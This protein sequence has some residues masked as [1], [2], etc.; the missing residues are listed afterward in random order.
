[1]SGV[2]IIN[3]RAR[4][5]SESAASDS[6]QPA[7]V[8]KAKMA[9]KP[10]ASSAKPKASSAKPR[11]QKPVPPVVLSNKAAK[12]SISARVVTATKAAIVL[13]QALLAGDLKMY[14]VADDKGGFRYF[15]ALPP[16]SGDTVDLEMLPGMRVTRDVNA[17]VSYVEIKPV[18]EEPLLLLPVAAAAAACAS[19]GGGDNASS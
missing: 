17:G 5:E 2:V 12:I 19:S 10:R 6:V 3:K 9:A 7:A 1:M 15:I 16:A 4:S 11:T 8:K 13:H 18:A 14:K